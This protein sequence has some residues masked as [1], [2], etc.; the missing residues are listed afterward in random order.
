[1]EVP[2]AATSTHLLKQTK[3]KITSSE[4]GISVNKKLFVCSLYTRELASFFEVSSDVV[5]VLY[6]NRSHLLFLSDHL[7][8]CF[9]YFSLYPGDGE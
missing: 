8:L 9:P 3:R 7:K 6:W 1:M 4:F 2:K 5:L